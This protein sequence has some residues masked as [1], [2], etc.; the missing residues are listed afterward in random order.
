MRMIE[1]KT[2]NGSC[3]YAAD[4]L[5]L[6]VDTIDKGL[7]IA[8]VYAVAADIQEIKVYPTQIF[9]VENVNWVKA[10]F[11]TNCKRTDLV[12]MDSFI[13]QLKCMDFVEAKIL[14]VE[15]EVIR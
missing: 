15:L 9:P 5:K 3:Y 11:V 14:I 10:V 12:P 1:V 8:G 13:E 2:L 4:S 7:Y 6:L